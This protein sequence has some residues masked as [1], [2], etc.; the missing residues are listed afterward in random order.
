MMT[1]SN[2]NITQLSKDKEFR[3]LMSV[4]EGKLLV[5]VD[6]SALELVMMGHYLGKY[7]NYFYAKAV[8]S[9]DKSKGT[10]IHT[11][12]QKVVG[13]PSRDAAKT[14]NKGC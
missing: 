4:P 2:P 7:D 9:G 5:D 13:L 3:E 1:H 14:L 11:I 10:D 8:D 6:A 12:N